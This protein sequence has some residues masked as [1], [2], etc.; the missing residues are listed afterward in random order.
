MVATVLVLVL[1]WCEVALSRS[2]RRRKRPPP[3]TRAPGARLKKVGVGESRFIQ[4]TLGKE[5]GFKQLPRKADGTPITTSPS[6]RLL[7]LLRTL[8]HNTRSRYVVR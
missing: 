6:C 3:R 2:R 8:A 1:R 7:L 5:E 4:T